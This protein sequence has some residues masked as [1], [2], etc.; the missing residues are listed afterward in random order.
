MN[1]CQTEYERAAKLSAISQWYSNWYSNK[2]TRQILIIKINMIKARFRLP[3][4]TVAV[5]AAFGVEQG[6]HSKWFQDQKS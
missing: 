6:S 1:G 3:G 5:E 4:R 2:E